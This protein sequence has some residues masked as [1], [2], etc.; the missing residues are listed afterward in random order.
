[1]LKL[2]TKSAKE[3]G[4]LTFSDYDK[5]VE[6]APPADKDIVDLDKMGG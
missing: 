5:P 6:A 3:P 2:V 4:A 1:M